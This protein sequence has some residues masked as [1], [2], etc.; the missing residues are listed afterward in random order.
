MGVIFHSHS[1]LILRSDWHVVL[2]SNECLQGLDFS[3]IQLVLEPNLCLS[4]SWDQIVQPK[5][6]NSTKQSNFTFVN[7]QQ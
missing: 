6:S 2:L 4:Y 1:I 3:T 5:N 7:L